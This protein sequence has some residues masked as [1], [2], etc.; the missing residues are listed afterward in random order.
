MAH[1]W[2]FLVIRDNPF[3]C[4]L[5]VTLLSTRVCWFFCTRMVID[6]F[7]EYFL[8]F[9]LLPNN[10]VSEK[11]SFLE[12]YSQCIMHLLITISTIVMQ[13][14]SVSRPLLMLNSIHRFKI[15]F[16]FF[17]A[18]AGSQ[19]HVTQSSLP[20]PSV[21]YFHLSSFVDPGYVSTLFLLLHFL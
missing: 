16:H 21:E 10:S 20:I 2:I 6:C 18:L 3:I 14:S 1:L 9:F 8:L 17:V 15:F 12:R 19:S 13:L 7:C 11:S 4:F 5:V